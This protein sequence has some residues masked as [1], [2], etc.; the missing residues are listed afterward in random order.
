MFA[1]CYFALALVLLLA[2]C[3]SSP[4]EQKTES[5]SL[6]LE[7]RQGTPVI[8][9]QWSAKLA[10]ESQD[11]QVWFLTTVIVNQ[12]PSS[13]PI[14]RSVRELPFMLDTNQW[15]GQ[16]TF[17]NDVGVI[18]FR[19]KRHHGTALGT[20]T[21]SSNPA[22]LKR[23]DTVLRAKPSTIEVFQL[24][25]FAVQ[26]E[27]LAQYAA[28]GFPLSATELCGLKAL[29]VSASY[30]TA[31]RQAGDFSMDDVKRLHS[32]GVPEAFVSQLNAAH[33]VYNSEELAQ[34]HKYGLTAQEVMAWKWSGCR[35][36]A[37]QIARLHA[38]GV[39]PR[40]GALVAVIA[41]A[42]TVEDLIRLKDYGLSE[43]YLSAMQKAKL[44]CSQ[45]EL[46]QL[47]SHGVDADYYAAWRDAGYDFDP[48]T[49]IQLRCGDVS[50]RLAQPLK[51]LG[52]KVGDFW[53]L[54]ARGVPADYIL[55]WRNAGFRFKA[56]DFVRLYLA[57]VPASYAADLK[58]TDTSTDD[59]L[60]LY[61][62]GFSAQDIREING[63]DLS[64]AGK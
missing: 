26:G 4:P 52:Y 47:H 62:K 43:A 40:F 56:E 63:K 27:E 11:G 60:R 20:F 48:A 37:F 61:Q 31:L 9:G 34:L 18:E 15:P 1:R 38:G 41:G 29:G 59:L 25:F 2:G 49:I 44:K 19:G 36:D 13:F 23:C 53:K 17:S 33:C 5:P 14:T 12:K 8:S 57:K 30:V 42:A 46:T 22:Y 28:S 64:G 7:V 39:S 24:A 16:T 10:R 45:E 6:M 54:Q 35:F 3:A 50:A 21:F 55:A 32:F 58:G 51:G